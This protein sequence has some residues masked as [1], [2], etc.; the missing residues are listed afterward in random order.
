MFSTQVQR[1]K[2]MGDWKTIC[3]QMRINVMNGQLEEESDWP[4]KSKTGGVI[5]TSF[6]QVQHINE[7]FVVAMGKDNGQ[8][9]A[10]MDGELYTEY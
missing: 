5:P 3:C 8:L 9:F 2:M 1:S 7:N 10:Y 6:S 4:A